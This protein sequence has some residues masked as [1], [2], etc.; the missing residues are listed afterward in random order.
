M[1]KCVITYGTFDLFHIGH[2]NLL[3]RLKSLGDKLVVAVSTDDFNLLKGKKTIIPFDQRLE[4]IESIKYV[5]LAIPETS[6]EQKI[7]DIKKYKIDIFAIGEDWQG[8]FDFM[9]EHCEVLYLPRT[10]GISS[11]ELKNTLKT[12]GSSAE[13]VGRDQ[14]IKALDILEQLRKDLE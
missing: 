5:D 11:T 12:F 14:I 8:K 6:W 7:D 4:I 10:S 13:S 1:A 9:K 3:K 2:L